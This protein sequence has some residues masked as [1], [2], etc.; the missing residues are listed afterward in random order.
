[1]ATNSQKCITRSSDSSD[2]AILFKRYSKYSA[3][4]TGDYGNK[5]DFHIIAAVAAAAAA[6]EVGTN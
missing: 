3:L 6:A 5:L 4:K 2:H 1:M